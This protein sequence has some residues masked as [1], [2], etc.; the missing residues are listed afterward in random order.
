[1]IHDGPSSSSNDDNPE[2]TFDYRRVNDPNQGETRRRFTGVVKWF[3][4]NR[5][6]GFIIRD[7]TQLDIY[8]ERAAI[9]KKN[10]D[11]VEASLDEGEPVEFDILQTWKGFRAINV[12]GP[13]GATVR[14]SPFVP[15]K[16]YY[17]CHSSFYRNK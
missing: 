12:T 15:N 10:P 9:I 14:G 7:D 8:V 4:L 5:G 16:N 6:M 1:M 11:K 17:H 13:N 2:I 3:N